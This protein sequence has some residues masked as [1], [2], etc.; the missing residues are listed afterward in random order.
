MFATRNAGRK[1]CRKNGPGHDRVPQ[2][3][4][5]NNYMTK[6]FG[7]GGKNLQGG[8]LLDPGG[9]R[10]TSQKGGGGGICNCGGLGLKNGDKWGGKVGGRT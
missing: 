9:G 10:K 8:A 4:G 3:E 5:G 6:D 1:L 7:K 2:G